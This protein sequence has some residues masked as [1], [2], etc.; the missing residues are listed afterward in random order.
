MK[1][2]LKPLAKP[3]LAG[4]AVVAA[5]V[6]AATQSPI[7]ALSVAIAAGIGPELAAMAKRAPAFSGRC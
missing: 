2:R 7:L 5:F 6:A 3:A 1:L 4:A